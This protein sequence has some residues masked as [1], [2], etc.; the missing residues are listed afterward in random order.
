MYAVSEGV[1]WVMLSNGTAWQVY[2]ITGGLRVSVD[3][4]L[5]VN[6]LGD[7]S[8]SHKVKQFFNVTRESLTKCQ[9]DE[10]WKTKARHLAQIPIRHLG[11]RPGR[12]RDPPRAEARNRPQ[13]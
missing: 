4:A 2:H 12:D 7:E 3:P 8:P 13:H 5:S 6:L 10:L 11:F 9:I 1:G